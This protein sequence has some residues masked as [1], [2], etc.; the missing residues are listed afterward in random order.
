V[1]LLAPQVTGRNPLSEGDVTLTREAVR[2][3]IARNMAA[4]PNL[5]MDVQTIVCHNDM[6]AV[7]EIETATLAATNACYTM[8][9]ACFLRV[10]SAGQITHIHNYWDTDAYFRQ[11]NT[12][13][14]ALSQMIGDGNGGNRLV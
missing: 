7:E 6:V 2:S 12:T 9:V 8:P 1:A 14:E 5:R 13:A 11:L 10:N 4:F 3:L